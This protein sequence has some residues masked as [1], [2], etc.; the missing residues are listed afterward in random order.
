MFMKRTSIKKSLII[1]TIGAFALVGC[2]QSNVGPIEEDR[3]GDD[4]QVE[5]IQQDEQMEDVEEEL[6]A[7]M[8]SYVIDSNNSSAA[9]IVTKKYVGKDA[10]VVKGISDNVTGEF[11]FDLGIS[12]T[13]NGE[14]TVDL[15]GLKSDSGKRDSDIK[16]SALESDK[17]PEAEFKITGI[18]INE[19]TVSD[20]DE[21]SF[22]LTGEMKI[23]GQTKTEQL[24]VTA[25]KDGDMIS[26]IAKVSILG[27]DYGIEMPNILNIYSVG[28]EIDIEVEFS[29]MAI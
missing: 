8:E 17:Y 28:D 23:H 26:G 5:V 29:A 20:G 25:T 10:Q 22:V 27:S 21:V 11:G 3:V 14:F 12:T 18:E 16:L 9:Y 1:M 19:S 24:N 15:I 2:T 13:A 4:S 6:P 7:G